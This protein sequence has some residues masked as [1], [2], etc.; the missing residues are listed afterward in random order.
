MYGRLL[1]ALVA[2]LSIGHLNSSARSMPLSDARGGLP[3]GFLRM[4]DRHDPGQSYSATDARATGYAAA[5]GPTKV[6]ADAFENAASRGLASLAASGRP[7]SLKELIAT[8]GLGAGLYSSFEDAAA[9][10]SPAGTGPTMRDLAQVLVNRPEPLPD[11]KNGGA[12]RPSRGGYS[13]FNAIMET[14]LDADFIEAATEVVT[15]TVTADGV[16]AL[17]FMGLR[18]FAFIVSPVTNR[19]QVMDFA[20]GTTVTLSRSAYDQRPQPEPFSSAQQMPHRPQVQMLAPRLTMHA[21]LTKAKR[22]LSGYVLHPFTLGSLALFSIFWLV[23]R[24][25]RRAG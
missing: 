21:V 14:Q 8:A 10:Q 15:P 11:G 22:F 25:A 7:P 1:F 12:G 24:M 5:L 16:I 19:I 9:Q 6:P 23:L 13:L 18:E 2:A 4:L 3:P 20:T 17:S